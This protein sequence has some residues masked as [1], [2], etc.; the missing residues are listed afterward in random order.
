MV[1]HFIGGVVLWCF[2]HQLVVMLYIALIVLIDSFFFCLLNIY[3]M[4]QIFL[5]IFLTS[6]QTDSALLLN[7]KDTNK[8]I[9]QIDS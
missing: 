3:Y 6:K 4:S 7:I 8:D 5:T 1:A 9:E 2:N